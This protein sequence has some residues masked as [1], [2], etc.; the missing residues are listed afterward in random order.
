MITGQR[1]FCL[2]GRTIVSPTDI[3]SFSCSRWMS[4]PVI[5]RLTST[6][7]SLWSANKRQAMSLRTDSI[8]SL[9][10][11]LSLINSM[12]VRSPW[13][14]F[15]E[16]IGA[17]LIYLSLGIAMKIKVFIFRLGCLRPCDDFSQSHSVSAAD[18]TRLLPC[19]LSSGSIYSLQGRHPI[20]KH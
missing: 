3:P 6:R 8:S 19:T 1:P 11:S 2:L 13:P 15:K 12:F 16:T 17:I 20:L 10:E 7:D 9:P 4:L 18:S 5:E 14:E